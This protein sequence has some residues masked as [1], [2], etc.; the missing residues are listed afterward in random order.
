MFISQKGRYK[1][2]LV[3]NKVPANICVTQIQD[4]HKM[5]VC[6]CIRT[7]ANNIPPNTDPC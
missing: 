3:F 6:V 1:C 7:S 5:R 2:D 4:T